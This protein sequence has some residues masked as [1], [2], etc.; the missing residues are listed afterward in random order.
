MKKVLLLLGLVGRLFASIF[1]DLEVVSQVDKEINDRL[2]FFYNASFV[3]GYLNMPSARMMPCGTIAFGGGVVPPYNIY[4]ANFQPFDHIE[5]AA[6][7]RVYRG[8]LEGTFGK[9]GFGDDADR[10]GNIKVSFLLPTDGF[11]SLPSF[12]VGADDFFGSKRFNA[13]YI[14]ATQ[15]WREYNFEC[16]LGW[17][18][19]RI[20]GLF[21]GLAWT[22][23]RQSCIPILKDIS[24]IA[25]YDAINYKHHIHEHPRGRNIKSRVNGGISYV[26]GD[27]LQLTVNSVRGEKIAA[28]GSIRYPLGSTEG[29]FPKTDDAGSYVSPIDRESLGVCRP[30]CDFAQEL[31]Y[32]FGEQGLDLYR[33]TLNE[34]E[35]WLKIIN[36]RYREEA[37]V[38]ERI[39]Q[40][41]SALTPCNI[42]S[43]T[44]VIEA[45]G[46][47]SQSYTFRTEDLCRT[48]VEL[49]TLS[50]MKEACCFPGLYDAQLLFKRSKEVWT[51][52]ARPYL[53]TF[54]GGAKGKVKYDVGVLA[55]PEGYLFDE[56]YYKFQLGYS[57][58]ASTQDLSAQD[59]LNPSKIDNV[60]SDSI[61]YYQSNTFSVQQMYLQKSFALSKGWF[62]RFAGGYFEPAYGGGAVEL[63][64]YPVGSNFAIGADFACVLKRRYHGI[65]FTKK[66]RKVEHDEAEFVHF[67]GIQYFLDL[68]YEYAP[69]SLD[70]KLSI[71]QFLAK[72]KGARIEVTRYFSSG[73][74]FSLWYTWTSAHDIVNGSRYQDKGFVFLIPLDIFLRQSSRN[75]VGYAMS[76]WLRDVGAQAL[77]G[78][79][80][81]NTIYNER[82]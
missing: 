81:H 45:D 71:G 21:G 58:S 5:L 18:R 78:K 19:K 7:Y 44:V 77:T 25:E 66:V 73:L 51:F 33:V 56:I 26:L 3:G 42:C 30:E 72:D 13:Q 49:E 9:E 63:L 27:T 65:A 64:Y 46:I 38:R 75:Y 52:T 15:Q 34:G 11:P 55:S 74:R 28:T 4:A 47:P 22:P 59:R 80:L 41:L 67:I 31:A 29:L 14:V 17:G 57:I 10:V 39:E 50:P 60:R 6:N 62:T 76:A 16:S 24:L 32:A 68:Y 35:L 1:D 61:K 43:T 8:I 12:A 79:E 20:D 53:I 82:H 70:F 23:F 40:V 36:N 48:Q 2:P 54:F 37:V 69:L